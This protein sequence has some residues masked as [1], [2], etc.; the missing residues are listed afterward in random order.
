MKSPGH[1]VFVAHFDDYLEGVRGCRRVL[2]ES[3]P[4]LPC[5]V[6]GHSMGGLITGRLLLD[7]QDQYQGASV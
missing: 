4:D 1:R 7:D 3:Y 5:F 6:L 2:A